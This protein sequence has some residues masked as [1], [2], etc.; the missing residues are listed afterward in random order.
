MCDELLAAAQK[1]LQRTGARYGYSGMGQ[2]ACNC[3]GALA[4][5]D[6]H[7]TFASFHEEAHSPSC[8]WRVL[9]EAV[10]LSETPSAADQPVDVRGTTEHS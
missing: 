7:D 8:P 5:D 9:K 3:C 1:L 2:Y 10:A 6:S 4:Y